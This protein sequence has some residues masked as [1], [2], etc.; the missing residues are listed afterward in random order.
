MHAIIHA[1]VETQLAEAHEQARAALARLLDEGLSRHDAVH[2]IGTVLAGQI[3]RTMHG[4]AFNA[5]EYNRSLDALSAESW[6]RMVEDEVRF[7]SHGTDEDYDVLMVAFGTVARVCTSAMEELRQ[8]GISTALIRPISLFPFPYEAVRSAAMTASAVLVIELSAGQ[9]IED[10]HL[11][12][13]R[14]RP[15]HFHNRLGGMLV[16]PDEVVAKVKGSTS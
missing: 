2:A 8:E 11:A 1:T 3:Y 12:L 10:V 7:E 6:Q 16:S 4:E 9:M 5:E 13:A 15:V 14:S